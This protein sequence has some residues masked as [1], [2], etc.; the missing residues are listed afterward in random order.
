MA[1]YEPEILD[2]DIYDMDA[3]ATFE[4]V[5]PELASSVF[6][7][8]SAGPHSVSF[9]T[10]SGDLFLWYQEEPYTTDLNQIRWTLKHI[11]QKERPVENT[12]RPMALQTKYD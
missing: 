12:D 3:K 10:G 4:N 11:G 9:I 7:Y 8:K 6:E 1:N 2:Y 5:L